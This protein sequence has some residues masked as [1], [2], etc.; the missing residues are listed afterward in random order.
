MALCETGILAALSRWL[1]R[2]NTRTLEQV[3]VILYRVLFR[4]LDQ[5]YLEARREFIRG[6]L[7]VSDFQVYLN[8]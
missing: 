1:I 7:F 5:G 4:P 8:S 2:G 6:G 3:A